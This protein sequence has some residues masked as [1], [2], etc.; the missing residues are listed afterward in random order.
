[1]GGKNIIIVMDDARLDLA[2]E[3]AI[4]GGFGTSGQRCTAASRIS[5]HKGVYD[6]FVERFQTAAS[7][8]RL[9]MGSGKR[10]T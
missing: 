2:I 3:G 10:L 8:L 5:V 9:G 7:R 4:W 6:A 1:M